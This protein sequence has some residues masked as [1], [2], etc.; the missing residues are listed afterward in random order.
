VNRKQWVRRKYP[1]YSSLPAAADAHTSGTFLGTFSSPQHEEHPWS[2]VDGC[3]FSGRSSDKPG[4]AVRPFRPCRGRSAQAA[5]YTRGEHQLDP[6]EVSMWDILG[7]LLG[8]FLS[9]VLFEKLPWAILIACVVAVLIW[10][11]WF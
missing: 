10:L 2:G 9:A 3:P 8:E 11:Y 5:K 7:D 1:T 6:L 4:E